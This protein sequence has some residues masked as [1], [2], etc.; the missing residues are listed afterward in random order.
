MASALTVLFLGCW[1]ARQSRVSGQL[2]APGPSISISPSGVIALGGAVTI[3]CQCR[4]EGR[5]LFLYKGRF[6]IQ[7]LDAAG[8]GGEFT[9]PSARW[10]HGG[11]YSCRSHSGSEPPNWSYLSDIMHII[12]AELSYQKPS[13]SLHPSGEVTLG[14]AVTVR[15]QA[16]YQ[17][18][19]FL[20]YKDGNPNVLQDAEPAGDM[21]EFPIRNVSR[22]DAGSY[23]CYYYRKLDPFIWS[24]PS[25][26]VELV[27]ADAGGTDPTQLGA[28]LT[29]TRP[30]IAGQIPGP[31][32][33]NRHQPFEKQVN[34]YQVQ[35]R[36]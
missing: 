4:C 11:V 25:D 19:R 33:G 34:R 18:V 23:R 32:S 29:P 8:E 24:H 21:N 20:L 13:I 35:H 27:V 2:P 7:E 5:R 16:Q 9:I 12:V 3:R 22:R 30:G 10:E 28:T 15:C 26:T 1:L 6:Q 14:G 17:T 36:F 31:G